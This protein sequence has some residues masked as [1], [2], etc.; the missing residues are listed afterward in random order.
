MSYYDTRQALLTTLLDAAIVPDADIAFENDEFDPTGKDIWLAVYFLPVNSGIMGKTNESKSEQRGVFQISV[1]VRKN[2]DNYDSEQLLKID[3]ILS[4]F[5]Y[6]TAALYSG[7]TV[8]ILDAAL[9]NGRYDNAWFVRDVSID[10]LAF[11]T[12]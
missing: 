10:Y 1:F 6:G 5:S 8:D 9:T 4:T 7:Q 2:S 3:S 11:A 12:R